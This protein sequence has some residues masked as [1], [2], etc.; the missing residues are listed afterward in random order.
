MALRDHPAAPI[1]YVLAKLIQFLLPVAA[2]AWLARRTG[3]R[4]SFRQVWRYR[5]Q[6]ASPQGARTHH[7]RRRGAVLAGLSTGLLLAGGVVAARALLRSDP[8]LDQ[9]STAVAVR[10]ATFSLTGPDRFL[11]FALFLS[12]VHS[13]LEEYYW[14]WYLLGGLRERWSAVS[15]SVLSSVAFTSH[16]VVV[17]GGYVPPDRWP[18]LALGSLGVF[19][20]GMTWAWLYLDRRGI[21]APWLSHVLVDLAVL[22]AGWELVARGQHPAN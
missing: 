7:R 2:L 15:A 22:A 1:A 11:A 14:R 8:A 12:L 9:V 21:L 4:P 17:V 3:Q 19:L 16:H 5:P 6:T 13:A 10:M 18:L 20:A